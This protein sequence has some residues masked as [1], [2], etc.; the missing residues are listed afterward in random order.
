M[1]RDWISKHPGS[2]VIITS[3]IT[4]LVTNPLNTWTTLRITE[5]APEIVVG[6]YYNAVDRAAEVPNRVGELAIDYQKQE[7][8]VEGIYVVR[9]SNEGRAPEEN[10]RVFAQAAG[11]AN[12]SYYKKPD[13]RVYQPDIVQLDKDGFFMVLKSFPVSA[14]AEISF[15]PPEDKQQLCHMVIKAAGNE[16]EGLVKPIE[17]IACE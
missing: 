17:G 13:L 1:V 2:S 4:V 5:K 7:S 12:L 9:V 11:N 16:R 14:L 3:V 6:Q 8:G 10:L 15:T